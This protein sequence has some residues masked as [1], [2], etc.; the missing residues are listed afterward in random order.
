MSVVKSGIINLQQLAD[1]H[2]AAL[3]TKRKTLAETYELHNKSKV[4]QKRLRG[5]ANGRRD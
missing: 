4:K 1:Q 3:P 2:A 5:K